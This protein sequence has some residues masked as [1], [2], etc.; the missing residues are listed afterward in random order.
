MNI[1]LFGAGGF[2]GKN[3]AVKL[4]KDLKNNITAVDKSKYFFE[5]MDESVLPK[6]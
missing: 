4:I 5:D 2:I 1:I 6:M 3:L